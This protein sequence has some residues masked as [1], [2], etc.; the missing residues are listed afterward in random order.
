MGAASR[1]DE[2]EIAGAGW[3]TFA[4]VM[5]GLAGTWNLIDGILALANSKVY[6]ATQVYVFSDLRTWGWITLLVGAVQLLAAF[7][8]F[9][10]SEFAR[11]FGIAAAGVNALAQLGFVAVYPF[12]AL[13]M[14][15]VDILVIYA[16]AVHAGKKLQNA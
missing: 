9:T 16:L 14:F 3:L 8:I 15:A 7:A 4:A 11:W 5:L 2:Y 12:W 13:M 6:G 1:A 10:G